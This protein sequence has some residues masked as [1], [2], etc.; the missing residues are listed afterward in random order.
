MPG[1]HTVTAVRWDL[2]F[3]PVFACV[4]S[5]IGNRG[6]FG[7][8]GAWDASCA[9]LRN[10]RGRYAQSIPFGVI[11]VDTVGVEHTSFVPSNDITTQGLDPRPTITTP[12]TSK[13][14]HQIPWSCQEAGSTNYLF[15][16]VGIAILLRVHLLP[17]GLVHPL[18]MSFEVQDLQLSSLILLLSLVEYTI[19]FDLRG[20][21]V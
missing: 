9:E 7:V 12:A 20:G 19:A 18:N 8:W 10:G 21:S 11:C 2:F 4:I 16:A 5:N 14:P 15:R 6:S 1:T 13:Y 17:V 3:S